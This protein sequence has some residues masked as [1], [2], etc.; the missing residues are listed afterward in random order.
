MVVRSRPMR[1]TFI[2]VAAVVLAALPVGT[3]E[4]ASS[5]AVHSPAFANGGD[6]PVKYTCDGAD[7]SPPLHFANMP[8]KTKELVLV[9]DDPDAPGGTFTHWLLYNVKGS[10]QA[11]AEGKVP[12]GSRQG[13]NSFGV[14]HYQGPCPPAFQTHRYFF[15]VHA[16]NKASGLAAGADETSVRNA[17]KGKEIAK[18]ALM[19][20]YG[21]ALLDCLLRADAR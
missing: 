10:T 15:T 9:M 2:A 3:A 8:A 13:T 20:R 14:A 17:I 1:R 7:V 12:A 18:G 11:I 6:I 4:S 16:L 19:G 21:C 5:M